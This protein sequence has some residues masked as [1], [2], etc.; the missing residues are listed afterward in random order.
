MHTIN[1]NVV[2]LGWVSYFTDLASAMVNPILPIFIVTVLHEG[3]DKLGIIVAVATFVSYALRMVSGYIADYYGV[4][5]PLVVGG[6]L[7]SALSKPLLGLSQGWGSIAALRAL[8]RMGKGVRSAPKDLMIAAYSKQNAH[9]KTFGFHKTMDIAGE[10][11]GTLLLFGLLWY[12]GES[13]EV[14]RTLFVATLLPG[15][16]GVVIVIFLVRDVPKREQCTE[17]FR[18]SAADK[19]TVM[20]L[21]FYFLFLFFIFSE[22]FFTVQA[23]TVGIA[24]AL[25]PLL[26]AVSTGVQTLTSYLFG[27]ASDRF[28]GKAVS[29]LGYGCGIAAQALLWLQTPAATWAAFAFLGLFTVATLNANRAMIAEQADNRG[30]VYGI[31]YAAVAL[32][33]AAGAAFGGWLWEQ[34]GM[35]TALDVALGGTLAVSV[36]YGLRRGLRG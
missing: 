19:K 24:T 5:K 18:L 20:Q 17:R 10:F 8:E 21:L 16:I 26:F 34:F 11:S 36:L 25:I 35:Q 15:I 6:Y 3:M 31:F 1:Q 9:G 27:L 7:L 23:K 14:I 2:R 12:F 33:A 28:G 22:A 32:F 29:A 4:V 30:S 13:E